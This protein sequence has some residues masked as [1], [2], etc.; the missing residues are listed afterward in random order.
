VTEPAVSFAFFDP[1]HG[2]HGTARSGATVLFADSRSSVLPR[3][4][5]VER[6][7]GGWR[8]RLEGSFSL[9]FAP[10][11]AGAAVLD[12]VTAR[13]C[14]VSGT[15][16]ATNVRCLGTVGETEA[17]PSWDDL[18]ALRSVSA[19]FDGDHAFLALSRR[20]RG[21]LGHG[22]ESVSAWLL[23]GGK[24]LA[25]E[26]ARISTVYDGE[27][28]QRSAGLEL[29]IAGEDFPRRISGTVVAGSSLQLDHVDVHAAIFRWRMEDREGA[30]A[31]ELWVRHDHEAA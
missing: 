1:G 7:D 29:W 12:G 6:R 3:G 17:P 26:D 15:V 5:D 4:P 2:L 27:G 22:Q 11:A 16:G 25:T 18:D 8:V 21:A 28:R 23:H 10:V 31:Y 13:V 14:E 9:E 30:G 24:P 20:P 19:L